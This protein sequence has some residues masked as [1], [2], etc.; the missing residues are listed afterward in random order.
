MTGPPRLTIEQV[1]RFPRPGT[2]V[3]AGIAFTPD[4]KAVTYLFSGEGSLV[5]SL[6]CYD[7]ASRETAPIAGPPGAAAGA[8]PASRE[9]EL[10]RERARLRETGVTHYQFAKKAVPPVLLVPMAA[11]LF[12]RVGDGPLRALPGTEGALDARLADGGQR[13]AF[14]CNGELFAMGLDDGQPRQLTTG[15]EEGFTNGVAEFIAQEELARAEGYWWSPDASRIAFARA[16][17]RH[18]PRFPIVHQG[19]EGVDVEEHRY[20]FAGAAN[21]IVQ[22]AIVDLES[23]KTAWLETGEDP[24]SY[25]ARAGWRPDGIFWA[26]ILSRDQRT[27]RVL[28]FED[29]AARPALVLELHSAPWLNLDHDLRFLESGAL[30]YSSEESGFRHLYFAPPGEGRRQ[31]TS[32]DWAVTRLV[33]VDEAAGVAFFMGTKDSVLERHLYRVSLAGGA[34]ERMTRE[35]G[36]H[37]VTISPDHAL[38]VDT[39]SALEHGPRVALRRID[40]EL[41]DMLFANEGATAPAL[42]LAVPELF[43]VPAADGTTTLHATLYRT[44]VARPGAGYPLVVD[45]YGGPHAQSVANAWGP[46][47]DLRNQYL[48]QRGYMVLSVDNRGSAN[49]GLAFEA[50][51]AGRMGTVEVDD[52]VAA[53]RHL[54]RPGEIDPARVAVYGW[55]YGGYMT[56]L[57]LARAP[58]VFK[59]G[60]AGA[61]VTDWDGY[62]TAYTERYMG[63]PASNPEGYRES[64][65][66]THAGNIRGKLLLVHGM[67]DENVHFRHTAR[68]LRAF[69]HAGVACDL[70]VFPE[71]RHMPRDARG[72]EYQERR[73]LGFIEAHL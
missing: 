29:P 32:G 50:A 66:L 4:S 53:V 24:D 40:G 59:L 73:V 64:S 27:L 68:L 13:V 26:A 33:D 15:A 17:S 30:L 34:A 23:G 3:P 48:A 44:A 25:L 58:D 45:V 14:V 39:W 63:T 54:A 60:V 62:D 36:W 46:T 49:R 42:G 9:E 21:A 43:E 2:V 5:R 37:D 56:C 47:V 31:L 57:C 19:Q 67:V 8:A 10:R 28:A 72:L 35:P 6:Y 70:L 51:I 55:S 7:V 52:Q 41:Q 65:V 12:V 38:F 69:E 1:A 18:I 61:P 71:E 11:R 16:D 22:L 20:P